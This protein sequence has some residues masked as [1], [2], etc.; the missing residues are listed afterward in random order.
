MLSAL[1]LNT[2]G[3]TAWQSRHLRPN[4]EAFPPAVSLH[5]LNGFKFSAMTGRRDGGSLTPVYLCQELEEVVCVAVE[6]YR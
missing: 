2:S 4:E 5:A 3:G 6:S 1:F